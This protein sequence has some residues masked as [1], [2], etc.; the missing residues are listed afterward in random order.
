M[1]LL[2]ISRAPSSNLQAC[3]KRM[4]WCFKWVSSFD[5]DFNF[6]YHVS[7]TEKEI[8]QGKIY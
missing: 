2:A 5:S 1:T 3:K 4:G 7:F 6:D 8:A